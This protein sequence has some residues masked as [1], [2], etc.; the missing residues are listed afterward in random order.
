M[1]TQVSST[2]PIYIY[3]EHYTMYLEGRTRRLYSVLLYATSQPRSHRS[4]SARSMFVTS[5]RYVVSI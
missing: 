4:H 3:H 2:T 5:L 1:T